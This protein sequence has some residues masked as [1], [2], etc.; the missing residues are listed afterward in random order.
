MPQ[1]VTL[2]I[3]KDGTFTNFAH[4]N[5]GDMFV[6]SPEDANAPYPGS[7]Y[8]TRR[9]RNA[10]GGLVGRGNRTIT[11]G[12]TYT[13]VYMARD[14]IYRLTTTQLPDSTDLADEST[15]PPP[16]SAGNG[17]LYVGSGG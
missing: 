4:V 12:V 11:I 7:I 1:S 5:P 16:A 2:I 3:R 17:D 6:G 9:E 13:I 14:K 10:T 8:A 15:D